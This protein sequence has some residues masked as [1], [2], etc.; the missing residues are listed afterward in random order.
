V[1]PGSEMAKL[2]LFW[3]NMRS[4][5][6]HNRHS[7]KPNNVQLCIKDVITSQ[8][9]LLHSTPNEAQ[10]VSHVRLSQTHKL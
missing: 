5:C 2:F 7:R 10:N 6:A 9:G 1:N 4:D 3:Y 8:V